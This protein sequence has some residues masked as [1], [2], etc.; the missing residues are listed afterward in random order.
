MIS[1]TELDEAIARHEPL[2]RTSEPPASI[3]E[4]YA[5]QRAFVAARSARN[6]VRTRRSGRRVPAARYLRWSLVTQIQPCQQL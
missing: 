3:A 2:Q 1:P 4:A 5:I 6:R